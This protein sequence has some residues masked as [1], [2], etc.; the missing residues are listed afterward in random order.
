MYKRQAVAS[1]PDI[2][3]LRSISRLG[4]SVI[5]VVFKD[6]VDVYW[7]RQQLGERLREAEEN[8]PEGMAKIELAPI[9]TGL[10]EIYPVSYTHLDVYKRQ[11]ITRDVTIM[12]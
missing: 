12:L 10:G 8:I 7:A 11:I 9:S 4:L 1:I 2:I 3:E 6:D 5:T